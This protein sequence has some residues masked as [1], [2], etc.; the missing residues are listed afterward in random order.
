MLFGNPMDAQARL[1]SLDIRIELLLDP[2]PASEVGQRLAQFEQE[3]RGLDKGWPRSTWKIREP[4]GEEKAELAK[5]K[6]IQGYVVEWARER[7]TP[8]MAEVRK[9]GGRQ[10]QVLERHIGSRW[11]DETRRFQKALGTIG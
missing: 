2:Q 9:V 8:D 6:K 5:M 4:S 10:R 11:K 3:G 1:F 7:A